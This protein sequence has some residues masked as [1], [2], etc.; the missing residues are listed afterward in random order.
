MY[1]HGADT[2]EAANRVAFNMI[3]VIDV[4]DQETHQVIN[5]EFHDK[6]AR[7]G[8]HFQDHHKYTTASLGTFFP[9][10]C[11][12][13]LGLLLMLSGEQGIVYACKSDGDEPSQVY[14]RPYDSWASQSDWTISLLSG[15]EALV[16]AA[17]GEVGDGMGSV[18]VATTK[19]Y[20]R[21]LSSSGIQRYLWRV[22]EEVVSMVAGKDALMVV[23]RE[24]GTSSD[25]G[26]T[27]CFCSS[28]RDRFSTDLQAHRICDTQSLIY[29]LLN[30]FKRA[31]SHYRAKPYYPGSDS[32]EMASVPSSQ[33]PISTFT[34]IL[35]LRFQQFSIPPVCY[36]SWIAIA[37]RARLAG[38]PCLILPLWPLRDET[39]RTGLS[40]LP[41]RISRLSS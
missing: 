25:G 5:V 28:G 4:T 16:V 15:E 10:S 39:R 32:A 7:R 19:G 35:T 36:P 8:Y 23:H 3:G 37:A 38:S 41:R 13:S 11:P 21:F 33:L 18:V 24:G 14:Y 20:V 40:D 22:G 27:A 29:R 30:L 6:S 2:R 17:G 26:F 34:M 12:R 9:A 31:G 1:T